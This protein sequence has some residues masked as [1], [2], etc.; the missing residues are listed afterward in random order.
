MS[1][2]FLS[3]FILVIV[4]NVCFAQDVPI[5]NYSE[6][7]FGQVELTIEGQAD[8][9]YLLH[10]NHAPHA[11]YESITSLTMGVDGSMIISEPAGAYDLDKY[12]ITE[13]SI[14]N[15]GDADLDGID[16]ISEYNNMPTDAPLNFARAIDFEDG[17]TSI[18]NAETFTSMSVVAD[19]PWAP[20]LNGQQFVKFGILDRD[21]DEPKV[22]FI[23]S[24]THFIHGAF[25][26][27]INMS[28]QGDDGSGEIVFNP[29]D[30]SPNGAVGT[31]SFNFSFGEALSF[32]AT[33]RTY[34]LLIANMP[35]LKNNMQHFIGNVGETTFELLHKDDYNGSRINVALESEVFSN[36]DYI[37]FNKAEGF[38]F[39]RHMNLDETPGSRD[40]VLYDALPNN[41]P[42][43]GG[44][45][46]SVIQTP[47][48]HVNL[49]AIQDNVP[50]AYIKNP[51]AKDEISN[52]LDGYIYYKVEDENY[53]IR[54]ATLEE[55]NAWFED[56]RPVNP[57]IPER[58]LSIT[59]ILPLDSIEFS[60][61][62]SFGAKCSNV[63][64]MRT[65][66]FPEGTIPNGFGIPFYFYDEFMKYNNFYEEAEE[67]LTDHEFIADL[68]TRVDM[69]K[70]F[71]DDIKDAPLPQWML[72]ELQEMHDSFPEGTSIRC[73]SSTNNEDLPGFSGAG[74][75]T[76]KTQHPDEG[77]ISK[78]VKQVYASMWN[79]RAYEERNFY[80]VDQ[81]IA[82]M[83]ILCH[84]NFKD[85]KSNGVGV[86]ID[87]VN[88][89]QNT[90]YLNT[91]VG[92][93]LITNPDEN[94]I[95]EEILLFE[96]PDKGFTILRESNLVPSGELVMDEIYLDQ[97]R[98]YLKKIHDEFAILYNVEGVEGFGMDIEYKVT[99]QDQLSIKQARP[100]VSFWAD[101]NANFDLAATEVINPQSSAALGTDEIVKV[102]IENQGFNDMDNFDI[103][104]FVENQFIETISVAETLSPFRGNE[105]QFSTPQDFSTIGEHNITVIIFNE[106]D[107]YQRNDTL[108]HS[109]SKLHLLEGEISIVEQIVKCDNVVEVKTN[110]KNL[111]ESTFS[112]TAIEV[113]VNGL[114]VDTFNYVNTITSLDEATFD[115]PVSENFN[116]TDNQIILRLLNINGEM[117]AID[118]NNTANIQVTDFASSFQNITLDILTDDFPSEVSWEIVDLISGET[119]ALGVL[120]Q[121]I[122]EYA[123]DVCID[124]S[125]CFAINIF[126]SYGDGI[127]EPGFIHVLDSSG[128]QLADIDVSFGSSTQELICPDGK[129]CAFTAEIQV[130]NTSEENDNDGEIIINSANGIAPFQYSIDGGL[131]FEDKNVFSDLSNGEYL[132]VVRDATEIC[133]YEETVFIETGIVNSIANNAPSSISIYPNPSTGEFA[134]ELKQD[135]NI[136]NSIHI[137]IYDSLGN[138]IFDNELLIGKNNSK[139]LVSLEDYPAGHYFVKC[140]NKDISEY[141][142]IIKL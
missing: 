82:A 56:L 32:E 142:K 63:A 95:P 47:L 127:F 70:K 135:A 42:R 30:I 31:Y 66:G 84:P 105:Y 89:T 22:Y 120:V 87:P 136:S 16:D 45:I 68:E 96:D 93:S 64:T 121:G 126:D 12:R 133:F 55:V 29:N 129:G 116:A 41:L 79:F 104:L 49:R 6:N 1:I 131:T 17:T 130:Q 37:P 119:V 43:V 74:L 141:Y 73:R 15:P 21:T 109:F 140:Y 137:D 10:A 35:F 99:A 3:S 80:R 114:A 113:M 8:K 69:L 9:Y 38:G 34:E 58:D 33:Q 85:E 60:M 98:I 128:D 75:Y 108:K 48:S 102:K 115:I 134:I 2:R 100:W 81:Y 86:S 13:H 65:F 54:E 28:V 25:F 14:A 117:D 97:M 57:Q 20:F 5:L 139:L 94:A 62:T 26:D 92:E 44:I 67:I 77:H 122:Q 72:D 101:I 27:A 53:F 138:R 88:G 71:R 118:S 51:L 90:F 11:N 59:K 40:I 19:V 76:S 103:S 7:A 125:S 124:Y 50:N 39:F 123:I 83:G 18:D 36:I 107:T 4:Y 61:S 111:G 112:N 23:N 78:S 132:V 106:N 24:N 110:I 46:T 91:Q 52:L